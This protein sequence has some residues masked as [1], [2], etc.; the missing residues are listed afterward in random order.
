MKFRSLLLPLFFVFCLAIASYI[1]AKVRPVQGKQGF[2]LQITQKAYPSNGAAPILTATKVRY[3]KSDGSWK[4]ETTYSNGRVDVGFGQPGRGVFHV[5]DKNQRLDYVSGWS[6]QD[7]SE[8]ALRKMPGFV[9]EETILGY[10]TLH[11]HSG[12]AGQY[13]DTYLCPT[14][15]SYPLRAVSGSNGGSKTIF[16]VTQVALGEPSFG[17]PPNYPVDMARY[18]EVHKTP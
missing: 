8:D 4:T 10:K 3:Q 2:T 9:G 16:E 18:N 14:L 13:A 11:M 17:T 12:E 5:D 1:V 15:Q 6:G 7:L